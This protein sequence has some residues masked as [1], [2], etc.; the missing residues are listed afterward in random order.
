MIPLT[1]RLEFK[2]SFDRIMRRR[3]LFDSPFCD[4]GL[5]SLIVPKIIDHLVGGNAGKPQSDRSG[6]DDQDHP[7]VIDLDLIK[8]ALGDCKIFF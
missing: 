3:K 8:K 6:N 7:Q 4:L 5:R 1:V 2:K